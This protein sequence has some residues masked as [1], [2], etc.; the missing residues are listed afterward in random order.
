MRV[1]SPGAKRG[2]TLVEIL[3]VLVIIGVLAAI[4][5]PVL[6]RV[7]E[8]GRTTTCASNL[9]QIGQA[10]NLYVSDHGHRYPLIAH[11]NG[12]TWVDSLH[13]YIKA[14][15]VFECPS[16]TDGE[17]R[18]GCGPGSPMPDNPSVEITF[19]G[20]YDLVSPLIETKITENTE[21][22]ETTI[23]RIVQPIGFHEVRYRF[24]SK[25][26]LAVDGGDAT[27]Y[28]HN[29]FA[30][31]NPGI[32]PIKSVADLKDGGVLEK[33]DNGLNALFVDGHVK[34]HRLDSL[35][36]TA[37]WRPDGREPATSSNP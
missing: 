18:P 3:I 29:L 19:N 12:C 25:T 9:R 31:I 6:A 5:L 36:Q 17:Y 35:A 14:P 16:A 34:W 32:E 23:E 13:P 30:A 24:P 4:L 1:Q 37:M 11:F 15:E 22:G 33:H 2:F 7:R 26:I 21:S 28:F 20:S 10:I 27:H 8:G